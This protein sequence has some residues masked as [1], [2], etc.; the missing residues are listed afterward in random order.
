LGKQSKLVDGNLDPEASS[1]ALG[2]F[3]RLPLAALD[4]IQNRLARDAEAF[5]CLGE[6][7]EPVGNVG[8][9]PR[10]DLVG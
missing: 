3:D 1:A 9:E 7:H 2:D 10:G 4:L 8:H 6:G 5:G